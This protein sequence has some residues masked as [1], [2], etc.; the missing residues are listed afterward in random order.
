MENV[1]NP[2]FL[3]LNYIIPYSSINLQK[4]LVYLIWELVN[5]VKSVILYS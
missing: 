1:I 4:C 3:V 5:N 2:F